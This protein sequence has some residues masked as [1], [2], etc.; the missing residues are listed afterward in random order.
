VSVDIDHGDGH[1]G[2]GI[3]MIEASPTATEQGPSD[4]DMAAMG[5]QQKH[6]VT[7]HTESNMIDPNSWHCVA[8]NMAATV[9]NIAQI[10]ADPVA[11]VDGTISDHTTTAPDNERAT[12]F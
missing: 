6:A 1:D 12:V 4:N 9:N 11:D 2:V 5:R 8:T 3:G 7:Q 10:I